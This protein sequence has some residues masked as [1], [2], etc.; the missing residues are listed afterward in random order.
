MISRPGGGE[1]D[2]AN[3]VSQGQRTAVV[4]GNQWD[5]AHRFRGPL[6]ADMLALGLAVHVIGPAY[7]DEHRRR[8][9]AMGAVTHG[10][11]LSRS[12]LNPLAEL[13]TL[14]RIVGVLRRIRPDL[15]FSYFAKPV[16]Y[17]SIAAGIARVPARYSL[18]AG[19]GYVFSDTAPRSRL[20]R[21]TLERF[22]SAL[23]R[24]ALGRNRRVFFQNPDDLRLFVDSGLVA[25]DR[26]VR[27]S[28]TG[29][30]LAYYALHEPVTEPVTFVLAARLIRE[31][32]IAEFAAAA[33]TLDS[34]GRAVRCVLLG[35]LDDNP[36]AIARDE[37]MGWVEAG[38]LEWAGPVDDVRPWLERSSVYVLPS[39][40]REG[41]P[42]SIQEA[43][44]VGRAVITTD[45]SGCRETVEEG[46]NGFLVPPRDPSAL[47]RAMERY[48]DDPALIQRHGDESRRL[49]EERFE[50]HR[51]N[52]TMLE[53]MG[54]LGAD[55][56]G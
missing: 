49:A 7:E 18:I 4:I 45:T 56:G 54:L 55:A 37:V 30:D 26:A 2:V 33:R 40:Y 32:G 23:Y 5:T 50:V 8:I 29:V 13:A 6:L 17:G 20:G 39:Y 11:G 25:A 48:L 46:R 41:V 34:R 27:V 53:H 51:I 43:M 31:K 35:P 1:A 28:G 52:R 16:V 12:G 38:T 19:L 22:L 21:R 15:V 3:E 9:E 10:V 47:V 24:F 36:S 42:R 14:V 44:A